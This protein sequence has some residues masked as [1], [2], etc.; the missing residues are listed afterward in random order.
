MTKVFAFNWKSGLELAVGQGEHTNPS[1]QPCGVIGR[2]EGHTKT[3]FD[4]KISE[5]PTTVQ[6]GEVNGLLTEH[7][8][9]ERQKR[10]VCRYTGVVAPLSFRTM[11]VEDM[12][13]ER[14]NQG[15]NQF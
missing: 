8:V 15:M 9:M 2:R 11:L 13:F 1:T 10:P 14:K 6:G 3:Q 7:V 4:E 5:M 12:E